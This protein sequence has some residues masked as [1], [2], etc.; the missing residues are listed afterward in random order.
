[1]GVAAERL[2]ALQRVRTQLDKQFPNATPVPR[3]TTDGVATGIAALD[4]IL[5]NGGFPKGRLSVWTPNGGATAVLRAACV[6]TVEHGERAV[7]VDGAGTTAGAF[8]MAGPVLVRPRGRIDAMRAA[9]VLSRSGG[10]ALIVVTGV[11]PEGTENVRLSRAANDGGSAVVA[12]T[13][14]GSTSGLKITSRLAAD[15]YVWA[16]DPRGAPALV[17]SVGMHVRVSALG[18][19]R[20]TRMALPVWHDVAR[21]ALDP[22]MPDRRGHGVA[23]TVPKGTTPFVATVPT[24]AIISGVSFA[25][26]EHVSV[27]R[28]RLSV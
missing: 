12:L 23:Y 17:T 19:N 6:A 21:C 18:W 15:E 14:S 5:P 13:Q 7:W 25:S 10:F 20:R 26:A 24:A 4:A 28:L 22:A 9:E 16:R 3:R 11:E 27:K 8:W 2:Q 1:M